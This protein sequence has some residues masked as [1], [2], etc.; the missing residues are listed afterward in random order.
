MQERQFPEGSRDVGTR[1]VLPPQAGAPLPTTRALD[2]HDAHQ[3]GS[4]TT[5]DDHDDHQHVEPA[6]ED[7]QGE[8]G[9]AH[10]SQAH[11]FIASFI[12]MPSLLGCSF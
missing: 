10:T 9:L 2:G 5:R 1:G 6:M 3:E 8:L 7:G 4:G 11:T 12:G